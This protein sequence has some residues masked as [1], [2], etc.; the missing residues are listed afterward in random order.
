MGTRVTESEVH[1]LTSAEIARLTAQFGREHHEIVEARAA[2]CAARARSGVDPFA[3]PPPDAAKSRQ[4]AVEKL[5][6]WAPSTLTATSGLSDA[7]LAI[8]QEALRI[9]LSALAQ[10]GLAAA[11]A[12]Q[13]EW[14]IANGP[15]WR[16]L[17]RD[18]LLTAERM[19]ALENKAQAMVQNSGGAG[20]QLAAHVGRGGLLDKRISSDPLGRFRGEA[21]ALKIVTQKDIEGARDV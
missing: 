9:V 16:A 11:A 5:N 8:E 3:S 13:A 19:N 17:C 6:G 14:M 18:Y 20:L 15:A 10:K 1:D 12:D 21:L 7:E 4:I 2:I